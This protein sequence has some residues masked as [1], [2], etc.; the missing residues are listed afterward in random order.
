MR[1]K[2]LARLAQLLQ[3]EIK[4]GNYDP[5]FP[6]ENRSPVNKALFPEYDY[7]TN[8]ILA[9]R[10]DTFQKYQKIANVSHALNS[11]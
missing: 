6:P 1:P 3:K 9:K 8:V 5:Y 2:P 11:L 10:P 7:D 4:A